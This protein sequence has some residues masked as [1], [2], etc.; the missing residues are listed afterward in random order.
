MFLSSFTLLTLLTELGS[1]V[2]FWIL[3]FN[4]EIVKLVFALAP[5]DQ[6]PLQKDADLL[7][8]NKQLR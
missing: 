1:L 7:H 3:A 4:V 6:T 2:H 8:P 5:L